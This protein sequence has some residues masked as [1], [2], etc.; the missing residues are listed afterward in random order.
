LTLV[1][2]NIIIVI[3]IKLLIITCDSRLT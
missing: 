1:I 3:L 2:D